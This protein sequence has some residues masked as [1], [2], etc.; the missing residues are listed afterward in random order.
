LAPLKDATVVMAPPLADTLKTVPL[1][2]APP[3]GAVPKRLPLLSS[4]ALPYGSNPLEPLKEPRVVMV[5]LP[6][7]SLNTVPSLNV[8]PKTVVP[9]RLPLLSSYRVL[10]GLAPLLVLK[11]ARVVMVLLPEA[12]SN[13][14]PKPDEPPP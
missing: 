13:T 11:E 9:K 12:T 10:F 1:L 2:D 5:W 6:A 14:V 4:S 3:S 7:A 8:P